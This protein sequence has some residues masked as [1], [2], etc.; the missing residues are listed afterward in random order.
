MRGKESNREK[1]TRSRVAVV[2]AGV[3]SPLGVG[4]GATLAALREARDCVSPVTRFAVDQCR[5]STAGQV[6]DEWLAGVLPN[7]RKARRLHRASRMMISALAELREQ[8]PDFRPEL[9]VI[10]TTSGGMSFGE[11]YYRTLQRPGTRATGAPGWIANYPPQKPAVDALEAFG[12]TSPCQVIANACASGTNAIGHAFE[13]IRSGRYERILTGGYDAISELV[14]VGFDSLQA[15]TPEKCRPFDGARSGLVLGEGAALFALENL[16]VAQARGADILAE[17]TGYGISTDNHHLTQPHP[18]GIGPRQAMERALQSA[19]LAP[20]AID[21]VNAHGTA[22]PFNDAAE[23]KAIADLLGRV[24][25]SSTKGMMGHSLGAA[26]AIEALFTI[27]ALRHGF[28]PANINFRVSDLGL[29]LDIVANKVRPARPA[30]A[31][32]NSFGF[33]GANASIVIQPLAA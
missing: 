5:C 27:L 8:A 23:G 20:E 19:G 6:P 25:V 2:A 17:I 15:A 9:T 7:D 31:L 14:F 22:T 28:L 11:Q 32:S 16:A 24:P 18:S 12:L 29:D 4:L 3:V 13:C 10:G 30:A 26:G 1:Y 21:Y 33:G